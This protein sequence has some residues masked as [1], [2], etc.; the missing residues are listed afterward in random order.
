MIGANIKSCLRLAAGC[1]TLLFGGCISLPNSPISPTP[2]AYTLSAI[3]EIQVSKKINI[4]PGV[5]I[6]VGSVKIPEYLDRPQMV[7]KNKDGILKFDEFDRWGESL[8]IGMARLIREDL[9]AMLPGAKLTLYP[10]N[11]SLAVKY[12]VVVEV[13]QLDS[14][15]DRDMFLDV[16]WMVIDV[17]NS[18]TVVIKRLEFQRPIVPQ[19]YFGLTKI[20]STA[21]VSLSSQ[22]AE[23]LGTLEEKDG[24]PGQGY[25]KK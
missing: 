7:T 12:Q 5:I 16:Q 2:R 21:C 15:L 23:A 20:L 4:T 18:K 9:T 3:D 25:K 10:W 8:D 6:G 17:Q 1:F 22:I 14:E 11:P 19:N 24:A 13:I